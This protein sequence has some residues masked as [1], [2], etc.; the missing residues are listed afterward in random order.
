MK[1][2]MVQ[3]GLTIDEAL[4]LMEEGQKVPDR[5]APTLPP[6]VLGMYNYYTSVVYN[7]S[8]VL[9]TYWQYI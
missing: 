8:L 1:G 3:E 9:Y 7:L 5:Q 2:L 6:R 4:K